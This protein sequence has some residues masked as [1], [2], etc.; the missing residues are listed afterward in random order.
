MKLVKVDV[1]DKEFLAKSPHRFKEY[2]IIYD[3]SM[4]KCALTSI[5][6]DQQGQLCFHKDQF[7][8]RIYLHECLECYMI[9]LYE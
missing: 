4:K 5:R 2:L 3:E 9:D 8:N 1:T 7:K 6:V